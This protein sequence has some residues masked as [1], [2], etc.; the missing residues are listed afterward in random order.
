M[1]DPAM[2]SLVPAQA[3][4]AGARHRPR[5]RGPAVTAINGARGSRASRRSTTCRCRCCRGCSTGR[6][7][8]GPSRSASTC[9]TATSA[10]D[11]FLDSCAASPAAPDLAARGALPRLPAR[12]CSCGGFPKPAAA[13]R[14]PRPRAAEIGIAREIDLLAPLR[15]R[16]DL[17]IDTSE[18]S[19]HDL[20]GRTR[21]AGSARPGDAGLSVSVQSF[22]YKRGVPRGRRHGVRL[23]FLQNPHWDPALRPLDGRDPAVADYVAADPRF[24]PVPRPGRR[25]SS[26]SSCRPTRPRGRPISRS[27]FGCTGGQHRSVAVA[28]NLAET[29]ADKGWQVSIRHRELERQAAQVAAA[30]NR[31]RAA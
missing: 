6:R 16:A 5:R 9:A 20:Q 13:T 1:S 18:L 17:L 19:P 27:A 7:S 10:T 2:P 26:T 8:T 31:G 12:T 3:A 21:C 14:W 22:S 24:A 28:E 30:C 15:A 11:A 4:A 23:R 29:L 25:R